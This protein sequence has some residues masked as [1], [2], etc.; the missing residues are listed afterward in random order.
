MAVNSSTNG[1]SVN[2]EKEYIKG[3]QSINQNQGSI[4]GKDRTE[5]EYQN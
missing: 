4:C 1:P 5:R 3:E 2:K